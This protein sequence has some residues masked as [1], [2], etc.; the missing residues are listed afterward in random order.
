[1]NTNSV[2]SEYCGVVEAAKKA[3]V[4]RRTIRRW[5]DLGLLVTEPIGK[6]VLIRKDELGQIIEQ[7]GDGRLP[8]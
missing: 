7:R 5:I 1:M 6:V 4:T 3:G 8:R 2:A